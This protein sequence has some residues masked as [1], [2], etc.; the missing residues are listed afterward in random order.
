[1]RQSEQ[2]VFE[3]GGWEVDLTRRELRVGGL[4]VPI[5]DRAFEIVAVFVQ[6]AGELVTKDDIMGRV[7]PGAIVEDNTV[8][9]HI[10][11]IRK[12]L[13][14]DRGMLR[15]VSGRGYRLLGDWSIRLESAPTTLG[16]PERARPGSRP[17][18]TNVPVAASALVGREAAVQH[19][20]DL[21]SAYR[22][23]TLTGPGGIGKTVLAS[24]VARGLFPIAESDVLFVELGSLT[25]PSLVPSTVASVFGLKLGGDEMSPASVA[26]AIGGKKVLLILDNCEHVIDAAAR[27]VDTLVRLCPHATVLA[28]SREVLQIEGEFVFQVPAL[29]VPSP[30]R[31]ASGDVLGHSAVQLFITRM[32]SL[33]ADF[34]PDG[35][36]LSTIVAICR[37]LDGIPL[38]IE[39]A[40]ARAAALGPEEIAAHLDDRFAL[41][42][43]G[44]RT[45]LPRHQTLQATLD[46]SYRLLPEAEQ[47]LLGHLA[48]F[49]A[50]FTLE[51]AAAV[52]GDTDSHVA[53]GIS[54]LVS[55]S[56]VTL[57]GPETAPRWRLLET[58]RAYALERMVENNE[59]A[60]VAS[61]QAGY[62]RQ[63]LE[64][65]EMD[66]RLGKSEFPSDLNEVVANT[67]AA[68]DWAFLPGGDETTGMALT[69]VSVSLWLRLSLL[70]ECRERVE[71]VL[72][73]ANRAT[74]LGLESEM[75]LRTAL[76]MSLMYTRGPVDEAESIWTRVLELAMRVGGT[77]F[78]LR[79]LYG[80]WLYKVLACEYHTALK[81]S[82][83][84]RQVAE[85]CAPDADVPTADRMA[86]ITL[87]FL[88]DQA[89]A[90][91]YAKRA[92]SAPILLNREFRATH[93]GTDERVGP[94]VFLSRALWLQGFPDQ[95]IKA[96]HAGLEEADTVA[97]GNSTCIALADGA[98]LIS[99]LTGNLIEAERY[100][101]MLTEYAEK[102][103]LDVWRTYALAFRGRLLAKRGDAIE[104]A[105]L[106]RSALAELQK[107]PFDMRIQL[108]LT[109]LAETL[110]EAGRSAEAL[111][112]IGDAIR[113]ADYTDE[114][115][116]FPELL[117]LRGAALIHESTLGAI[118]AAHESFLESLNWARRQMALSWE[119][120]TSISLARLLRGQGRAQEAHNLIALCYGRFAEGFESKD[121]QTARQLMDEW[122]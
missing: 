29:E 5:G 67:R 76:G 63:R 102:H 93:Y 107:T 64:K 34:S 55:K 22:V 40:A 51:A 44:R 68:L 90:R 100:A 45:A 99:I 13:G 21:V 8:Q 25:D 65:M 117:R 88:G 42:T 26:R 12:A 109:W 78:H 46:W 48:I 59:H 32:R 39:F 115:W 73:E 66:W 4:A 77:E 119:L 49:P 57:D 114:R 75:L 36:N 11:S 94:H 111:L 16:V 23:V 69:I 91:A 82:E 87:H 2:I 58:I 10:S 37:R 30:R 9:V 96:M 122:H 80:L 62:C 112:A 24:E 105:K 52:L 43:G 108:Y 27:M 3:S 83:Q 97:H 47:R 1:V 60:A 31:G 14:A 85:Q 103:A 50:G 33:Q 28:T 56:L 17:F 79:A 104:G 6:S 84:F 15:T 54:S 113:R 7:W 19:L 72:N 106:L 95:A 71:K 35:K 61:R 53:L 110:S 98:C 116:Y 18:Q 38:A 41:L 92:L 86:E 89:A 101:A 81:L 120:R 118:K 70:G 20:R 74:N 121:L